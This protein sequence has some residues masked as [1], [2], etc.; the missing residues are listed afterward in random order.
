MLGT[1]FPASRVLVVEQPGPWGRPGL[2]A[3]HFDPAVARELQRRTDPAGIRLLA[4]RH[5][6]RTAAQ[7]RRLWWFADCRP[8]REA[9]RAGSF[10]ADAELLDV[11]FDADADADADAEADG[12]TSA[13]VGEPDAAPLILVCTHGKHDA[14]CALR[15]RPVAAALDACRPGRVWE[16]SHIGGDRF[17]A[18]VLV[19]SAGLVYGQVPAAAAPEFMDALDADEVVGGLLRGRIGMPPVAQ[20]ALAFAYEHLAL[21]ARNAL[22]IE[23]VDGPQDGVAR[24]TVRGPHGR[25]VVQVRIEVVYADGLTCAQSG[26]G[27]FARYRP[28]SVTAA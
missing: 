10:D 17:A 15:G 9:L 20:A 23:S 4:I 28:I 22:A 16:C 12:P 19:L 1:A 7:A 13:A 27:R 18:N 3:S 21:R 5:P 8:G 14:C 25:H 24:V 26:P 11:P 2:S 6:G